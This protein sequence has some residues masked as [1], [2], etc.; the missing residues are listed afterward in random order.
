M[1]VA[2]LKGKKITVMGLGLHGGGVGTVRF[3][4]EAGAKV[5]LTDLSSKEELAVSLEKL[6]GLKNIAY[7]FSQ[8]RPEDFTKADMV[9]KNPAV[10]WTN[11]HI[12]LALENKIPVEMDSSLFF[13][14]CPRPIIGV[15]GTKGKSTTASLI[16]EIL[17]TAGQSPVKV[18]VG[19]VSVLDKLKE[20][21]KDSVVVFE[22]SSW[23]LSALGRA[24]MSPQIAVITNIYPDHLNYYKT[25]DEYL[26][27]KKNIC[28]Y[29]D[30]ENS[31]VISGDNELLSGLEKEIKSRLIKFSTCPIE[32]GRAV[33]VENGA[34]YFNDG[35]DEKKVLKVEEI[36]LP[37]QHNLENVLA[38]IGA[39][40]AAGVKLVAIRE[41]IRLFKGIA[42]RLEPVREHLGIKYVNDTAATTPEAAIFGLN[43]FTAPVILIAGGADKNLDMTEWG[44]AILEKAKGVIFL[45]G[46]ATDK[47][48][49]S[50]KKFQPELADEKFKIVQSMEKAVELA[51]AAA[52]RGDV[53]LL[54]PGAASFG[55]FKNEFDRGNKF[56]EAVKKLK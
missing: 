43:S 35:I 51:R 10:P 11:K 46:P 23:R 18:G 2:D 48:I 15:T 4:S 56:K 27:D 41:G 36:N 19:Q 29:Q 55:M 26:K 21:K 53:V 42:H 44:K 3:L 12:K 14:F 16:F 13:K 8:H 1:N 31:C 47:I 49:L 22:L 6:K 30:R 7:V 32:R 24:K 28:L 50:M 37:G 52:E 5:T 39:A 25:M 17:K 20:L 54:S 34:I 33:Y 40:A 45:A 38:A 9:V